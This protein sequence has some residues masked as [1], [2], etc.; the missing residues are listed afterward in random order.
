MYQNTQQTASQYMQPSLQSRALRSCN[1]KNIRGCRPVSLF[2]VHQAEGLIRKAN[3]GLESLT[4]PFRLRETVRTAL[5]RGLL[6]PFRVS[7]QRRKSLA[8]LQRGHKQREA[9]ISPFYYTSVC[10]LSV[11][12]ARGCWNYYWVLLY[13]S[14]TVISAI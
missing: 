13:V 3:N 1:E 10:G 11:M 12:L 2:R 5:K 9:S 14:Y 7:V 6:M 8:K 4:G